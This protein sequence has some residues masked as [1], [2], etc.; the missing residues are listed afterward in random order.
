MA[1]PSKRVG[2]VSVSRRIRADILNFQHERLRARPV[3]VRIRL[4]M[5]VRFPIVIEDASGVRIGYL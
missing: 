2:K 3:V 4:I 5:H 1:L